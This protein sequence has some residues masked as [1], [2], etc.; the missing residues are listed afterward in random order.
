M[1][2]ESCLKA[3][4]IV[5]KTLHDLLWIS[6]CLNGT[7]NC[8]IH[9]ISKHFTVQH[10]FSSNLIWT[11]SWKL[12]NSLLSTQLYLLYSYTSHVHKH[13]EVYWFLP[14]GFYT[15]R[16]ICS[17]C[18]IWG[19]HNSICLIFPCWLHDSKLNSIAGK[20]LHRWKSIQLGI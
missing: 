2:H 18:Y 3:C 5:L 6:V 17:A 14:N 20:G 7:E 1:L 11:G 10:I 9:W 8:C 12:I 13:K 4:S 16:V 15:V 19:G